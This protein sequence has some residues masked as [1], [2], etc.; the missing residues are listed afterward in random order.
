MKNPLE[1]YKKVK[2]KRHLFFYCVCGR[3]SSTAL[4]R[5]VNSSNE[6]FIWGEQKYLIDDNLDLMQRTERLQ[7]DPAIVCSLGRIKESY[8]KDK[9]DQFY[10]NA[11]GNL[12]SSSLLFASAASN[13]LKPLNKK[14][15]RF[16]CKNITIRRIDTLIYLK[17]IFP[18]SQIIFLFR[19]P[20]EQWPSVKKLSTWWNYGKDI[21]LFLEEYKR[22]SGIYLEFAKRYKNYY[23][24]ENIDLYDEKKIKALLK[25]VKISKFDQSLVSRTIDTAGSSKTTLADKKKILRSVGYKNYLQMARLSKN[26]LQ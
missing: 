9:H 3:S 14:I 12:K 23:F 1:Y 5:I 6:A 21:N 25:F 24:I 26:F 17:K 18:K 19:N 11:L 13:F 2:N 15:N 10:P 20:L 16:G 8:K 4:Q 7:E 22:I